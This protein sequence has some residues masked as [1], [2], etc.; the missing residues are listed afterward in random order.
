MV[1]YP[2]I[3]YDMSCLQW[4]L[5]VIASIFL[6]LHGKQVIYVVF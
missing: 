2:Y 4:F 3:V 5:H 1:S 6:V